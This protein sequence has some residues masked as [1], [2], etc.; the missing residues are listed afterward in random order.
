MLTDFISLFF[1]RNCG[2]CN[3]SLLKDENGVCIKC[4]MELPSTFYHLTPNND[5]EKLFW[6]R[7][8]VAAATSLLFFNKGGNVQELLHSIKYK[9]HREA[10][11]QTGKLLGIELKHSNR[12]DNIDL[13]IPVPLHSK[14]LK[15]R[16]YNQAE[17]ISDGI[18]EVLE[19]PTVLALKRT[20]YTDSQTKKTRYNRWENVKNTFEVILPNKIMDKTVLLIDDVVTTGATLEACANELLKHNCTVY[21]ATVACA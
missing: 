10:G 7:I 14:R 12:F 16:G 2:A 11:I 8:S 5:V 15:E 1:P 3:T 9:S 21:I 6:G 4:Q 18:A 19:K 20:T 13:I 17:I